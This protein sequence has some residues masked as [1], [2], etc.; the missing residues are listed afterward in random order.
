[1]SNT[2]AYHVIQVLKDRDSWESM[3]NCFPQI[4]TK[5][6]HQEELRDFASNHGQVTPTG[7]TVPHITIINS[8]ENFYQL[9][10]STGEQTKGGKFY[11]GV[12][13]TGVG[14]AF[15]YCGQALIHAMSKGKMQ[16]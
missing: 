9:P 16:I 12:M 10:K 11:S 3:W 15:F 2:V 5:L 13:S 8:G 7:V 6:R 14:F 1:M 4:S